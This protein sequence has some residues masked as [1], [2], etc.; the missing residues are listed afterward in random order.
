MALSTLSTSLVASSFDRDIVGMA[1]VTVPLGGA[2]S[3]QAAPRLGFA[4]NRMQ[5]SDQSLG[6]NVQ[7]SML[8]K[9]TGSTAPLLLDMRFDTRKQNWERFSIG[10]VN[11][12]TYSTRLNADGTTA[13]E[14]T[15]F[16]SD[17][18][19]FGV[20]AGIGLGWVLYDAHKDDDKSAST[21]PCTSGFSGVL[22]VRDMCCGP[23]FAGG[24]NGFDPC[25]K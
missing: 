18:I 15:G 2:N 19:I 13:T 9:L 20:V 4:I 3:R 25:D 23:R 11:A 7:A 17:A 8:Q 12:L 14:A 21:P 22:N 6:S 10:G 16:S 5:Q 1:Y 24:L